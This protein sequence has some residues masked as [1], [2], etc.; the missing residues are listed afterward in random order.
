MFLV[1]YGVLGEYANGDLFI[2]GPFFH[3][4]DSDH[5]NAEILAKELGATKTKNQIMPW[6]FDLKDGE[7][8]GD[9]MIRI[10]KTW[11]TR[12]KQRTMETAKTIQR[13]IDISTCPFSEINLGQFLNNYLG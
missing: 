11:F 4:C 9:A 7:S 10:E 2:D 8:I 1:V 12:F 6:V 5:D 3:A 13:D